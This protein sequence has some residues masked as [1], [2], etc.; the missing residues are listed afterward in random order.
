MVSLLRRWSPQPG[1]RQSPLR[2]RV[3]RALRILLLTV[4]AAVVLLYLTELRQLGSLRPTGDALYDRYVRAVHNRYAWRL[5]WAN[6]GQLRWP[7]WLPDR[8]LAR[9]ERDFGTDPRY[10]ELRYVNSIADWRRGALVGDGVAPG[11][12]AFLERA[13]ELGSLPAAA[14]LCL[15]RRA[16]LEAALR[17]QQQDADR[18]LVAGSPEHVARRAALQ[19]EGQRRELALYDG[20]VTAAP[21]Q[22]W[23]YY[24]RA[25][26]QARQGNQAAAL[27]DLQRGNAA[28]QCDYPFVPFPVAAVRQRAQ[29]PK[30]N[31]NDLTAL[32]NPTAAGAILHLQTEL[33]PLIGLKRFG[34]GLLEDALRSRDY[35]ALDTFIVALG[36]MAGSPELDPYVASAIYGWG[37]NLCDVAGALR[38]DLTAG[39]RV[40]LLRAARRLRQSA[41]LAKPDA[42]TLA[43]ERVYGPDAARGNPLGYLTP[44]RYLRAYC[45]AE[46]ATLWAVGVNLEDD[47]A[48]LQ[49]LSLSRPVSPPR[50]RPGELDKLLKLVQPQP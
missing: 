42:H 44:G 29:A 18:E 49:T 41:E 2:R 1:S 28:A 32:G 31:T 7:P 46:A 38:P 13:L 22:A 17:K 26:E 33:P 23:G 27:A 45:R 21:E 14:G 35:A 15:E 50:R 9:W 20:L 47:A 10:W 39:Q 48:Y 16:A 3:I 24:L 4:C 43:L 40:A 37:R 34:E 36:R 11:E 30:F 8:Q 19:A 6:A 5:Y 25:A 12:V